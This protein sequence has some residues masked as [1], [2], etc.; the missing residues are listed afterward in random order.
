MRLDEYQKALSLHMS[1][2]GLLKKK[3]LSEQRISAYSNVQLAKGER[4]GKID[5]ILAYP[6][7]MP[8]YKRLRAKWFRTSHETQQK[9]IQATGTR[10]YWESDHSIPI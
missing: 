4:P 6:N 10:P 1:I 2:K 8:T 3:K 9:L 7:M 5:E